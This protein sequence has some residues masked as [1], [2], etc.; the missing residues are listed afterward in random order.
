MFRGNST[1]CALTA[2]RNAT[3]Y[4]APIALIA[5]LSLAAAQPAW[6]QTTNPNP[7]PTPSPAV[8]FGQVPALP[9]QCAQQLTNAINTANSVG[10]GFNATGAAAMV[11]GLSAQEA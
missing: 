9:A 3:E 8:T 7:P 1:I 5:V 10:L 4:C 2:R 11:V 6:A